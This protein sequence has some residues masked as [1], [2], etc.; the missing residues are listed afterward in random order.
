[1][2]FSGRARPTPRVP[3]ARPPAL[4]RGTEQA[5]LVRAL[6]GYVGDLSALRLSAD[7]PDALRD[8]AVEALVAA[9]GARDVAAR[10]ARAVD[11]LDT[12]LDRAHDVGQGLTPSPAAAATLARMYDRRDRLLTALRDG[13]A[14][15]QEVHTNL[16]ELSARLELYGAATAG[17]DVG[18]VGHRLDLL[19]RA[20]TELELAAAR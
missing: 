19:R 1:M 6:D 2:K 15:I 17:A 18:A 5:A 20:F 16:L 14:Q 3:H 11:G 12:A 13:L 7:L 9:R 4:R 10:V 8:P